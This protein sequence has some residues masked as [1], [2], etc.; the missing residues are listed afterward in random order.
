MISAVAHRQPS[1]SP[2]ES[3]PAPV[4]ALVLERVWLRARRRSAWLAHL[5]GDD[6]TELD[7]QGAAVAG[8]GTSLDQRDKPALEAQWYLQAEVPGR[9]RQNSAYYHIGLWTNL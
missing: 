3:N 9:E 2:D 6:D 5:L 8:F 7:A 4:L 1:P